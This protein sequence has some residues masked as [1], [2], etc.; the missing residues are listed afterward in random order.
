MSRKKYQY[1]SI[2]SVPWEIWKGIVDQIRADKDA[3]NTAFS[4][5]SARL[6]ATLGSIKGV[7]HFEAFQVARKL[8]ATAFAVPICGRLPTDEEVLSNSYAK[9]Y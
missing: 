4:I 2:D 6:H 3:G 7:L 5:A 8:K 9:K 1:A